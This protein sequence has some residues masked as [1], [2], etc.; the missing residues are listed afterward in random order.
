MKI[1][2]FALAF[3]FAAQGAFAANSSTRYIDGDLWRS[4][5]HTKTWTPPTATDTIVGRASTDTLTN[6]TMSGATNTWTG[7]PLAT[8]VTGNLPLLSLPS[9]ITW[10][11]SG[12]VQSVTPAAHGVVVS[13]SAATANVTAT[14]TAGQILTSG[15]PSADPVWGNTPPS[16]FNITSQSTTYAAT[17][18]DY[19]IASGASFTITLPT[20]VGVSGKTIVIQHN[21]TNFSQVYTLATTSGQTIGGIASGSYALYTKGETLILISDNANWQIQD[22]K[23]NTVDIAAGSIAFSATSAYTFTITSATV[24]IG[25]TYTN[26]GATFTISASGTVTSLPTSG[27]GAPAASGTLTKATGTGPATLTF[28]SVATSL[29][30]LGPQT[31]NVVSVTRFGRF[32]RILYRLQTSSAS[33]SATGTGDYVFFIPSNLT[34]DLTNIP[35]YLTVSTFDAASNWAAYI[36]DGRAWDSGPST[37]IFSCLAYSS[38]AFRIVTLNMFS[39][40]G[41]VSAGQSAF[42]ATTIAYNFSLWVPIVG[43]QP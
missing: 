24:V 43:W 2:N 17:I 22:H 15:G 3:L 37:K 26:N 4:A 23:T 29:P 36:G 8:A 19:I 28:A 27:T 7:I 14:G 34:M 39:A 33:G 9:A 38:T 11:A 40:L 30:A 18:N 32:A 13:G 35:V 12:T 25:D 6:K 41:F 10:P 31:I 20:A 16:F 1:F 42:T 21:G 5:D